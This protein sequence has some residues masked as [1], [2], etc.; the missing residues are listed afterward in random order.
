MLKGVRVIELDCFDSNSKKNLGPIVKHGWTPMAPILFTDALYVIQ[1]HAFAAS[2]FPLILTIENHCSEEN[3]VVQAKAL[4]DIL[5]EYLFA[6]TSA[7][8]RDAKISN[9]SGQDDAGV[10]ISRLS[11][12]EG[13]A[14]WFR[15]PARF[16]W[17]NLVRYKL[18]AMHEGTNAKCS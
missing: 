16:N 3:Q 2:D 6:P 11:E 13:N 7:N 14:G 12:Y 4:K 1:K 5:G 8:S 9:Q 10:D 18:R 17:E 15:S